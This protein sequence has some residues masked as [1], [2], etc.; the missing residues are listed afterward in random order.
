M[1]RA[2]A[3]AVTCAMVSVAWA[4]DVCIHIQSGNFVGS[5]IL[6]TKVKTGKGSFGPVHGYIDYPNVITNTPLLGPA[7]GQA[8]VTSGGDLVA[9]LTWHQG[10]LESNGTANVT[11]SSTTVRIVCEAGS[12]AKIGEGDACQT[13]GPSAG[14]VISCKDVAP[15]P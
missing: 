12:D 6:M 3:V 7:S 5:R 10:M 4:K 8:M 1:A 15:V 13:N 2:L 9:G 11:G 14:P